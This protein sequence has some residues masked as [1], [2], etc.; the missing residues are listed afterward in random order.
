M[1]SNN[2]TP[3]RGLF[4]TYC[5]STRSHHLTFV[6]EYGGPE[7]CFPALVIM[8]CMNREDD[9]S[10]RVLWFQPLKT[11]EE[12]NTTTP[13]SQG[14]AGVATALGRRMRRQGSAVSCLDWAMEEFFP[15]TH[16]LER[17]SEADTQT[18]THT[19]AHTHTH[20]HH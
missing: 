9:S 20:T 16:I 3:R 6:W 15:D 2:R 14:V 7:S 11:S 19:R 8:F 5:A 13:W 10:M 4:L 18:H 17:L 1:F 12:D